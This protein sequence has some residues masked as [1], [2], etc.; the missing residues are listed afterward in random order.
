MWLEGGGKDWVFWYYRGRCCECKELVAVLEE[1]LF[2]K[3]G[4]IKNGSVMAGGKEGMF[5]E[6]LKS[7]NPQ[8]FSR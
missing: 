6:L 8:V 3:S 7:T 5:V 2:A 4:V 1:F